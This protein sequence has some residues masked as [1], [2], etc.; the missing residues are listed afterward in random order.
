V[1][2]ADHASRYAG[3]A[4]PGDAGHRQ[5][6]LNAPI[7]VVVYVAPSG[8]G[9]VGRVIITIA[10]HIAAMAPGTNIGAHPVGIGI[11]GG[12]DKTMSTKVENDAVAYVR[13]LQNSGRNED[14]WRR[15]SEE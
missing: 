11:G 12:M 9:G 1:R 6:I 13:A 4:G 2:K 15:R 5:G 3:R 8:R 10:A 14:W 7:P